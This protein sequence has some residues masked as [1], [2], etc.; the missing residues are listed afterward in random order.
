MQ[1]S[2]LVESQRGVVLLIANDHEIGLARLG[3]YVMAFLAASFKFDC[4]TLL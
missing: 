3:I 4:L 2:I 1:L